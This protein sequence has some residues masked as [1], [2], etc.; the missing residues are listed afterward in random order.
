MNF[1]DYKKRVLKEYE[2]ID[3]VEP[4]DDEQ[5]LLTFMSLI[6]YCKFEREEA[7]RLNK[8]ERSVKE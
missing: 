8:P 5:L 2:N 1:I 4:P 3:G 6:V 7:K